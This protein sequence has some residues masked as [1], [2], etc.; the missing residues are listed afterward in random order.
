MEEPG[1]IHFLDLGAGQN[2]DRIKA[3]AMRHPD[4]RIIA[5]D[6]HPLGDFEPLPPNAVYVSSNVLQYLKTL[7][8]KSVQIANADFL[9]NEMP[10]KEIMELIRHIKKALAPNGRFYISEDRQNVEDIRRML[11]QHG[12]STRAREL[13]AEEA[14]EPKTWFT[15]ERIHH[16]HR[17]NESRKNMQV[18]WPVRIVAVKRQKR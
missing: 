3:L 4:R 17:W 5:V 13:S 9:L 6:I 12:F 11:H 10:D 2:P 1:R 15:Q 14:M 8:E 16:P 7:K 18:T